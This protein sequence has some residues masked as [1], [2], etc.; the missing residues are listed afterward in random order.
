MCCG[1]LQYRTYIPTRVS[2]PA[3]TVELRKF[4]LWG[5]YCPQISVPKSVFRSGCCVLLWLKCKSHFSVQQHVSKPLDPDLFYIGTARVK[6]SAPDLPFVPLLRSTSWSNVHNA[7]LAIDFLLLG[8][9]VHGCM[10]ARCLPLLLSNC[11]CF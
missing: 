6:L 2:Y 4:H 1:R 5:G 8:A 7:S 3:I 11:S 9:W 10:G